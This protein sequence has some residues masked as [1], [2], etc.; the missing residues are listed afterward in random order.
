MPMT[1]SRRSFLTGASLAG[2]AG[3]LRI[4]RSFAAEGPPETASV[5]LIR[6]PGI[7]IAPQ[8]VAEDLLRAEGFTEIRYIAMQS[9][10]KQEEAI[11]N[12]EV[13]FSLDFVAPLL[14]PMDAGAPITVLAG[15]HVGCFELFGNE[16]VGSI[17]DL[18]GRS[19]GVE[20]IGSSPYVFL[21]VMAAHV[22]LDPVKDIHWVTGPPDELIDRF[23]EG[24]IDAFLGFPPQPQQL[25]ARHAVALFR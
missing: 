12:G 13:D 9:G 11:G 14:L 5:R 15:V 6:T 2:T 17:L 24:K 7:C 19:V 25:H 20:G 8:Y 10:L 23:S 22:G 16:G 18:K 1:Q 21:A 4:P 3:L